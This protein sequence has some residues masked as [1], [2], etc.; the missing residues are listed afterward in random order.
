MKKPQIQGLS[1]KGIKILLNE[2]VSRVKGSGGEATLE[3]ASGGSLCQVAGCR[4]RIQ[5]RVEA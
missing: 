5:P 3:L 2:K 4:Y 1:D